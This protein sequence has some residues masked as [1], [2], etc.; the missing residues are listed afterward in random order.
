MTNILVE[1]AKQHVWQEPLQ[2][3]QFNI[4]LGRLTK[5]GGFVGSTAV[6]WHRVLSPTRRDTTRKFHHIYQ[7]GQV[8]PITLNLVNAF[9]QDVWMPVETIVN[10]LDVLIE[11]Y[12]ETGAIVPLNHVWIMRDFTNNL[13]L[14]VY[15]D[16]SVDYGSVL[17]VDEASDEIGT[18]RINCDNDRLVTRFY[19]NALQDNAEFNAVSAVQSDSVKTTSK[20][21]NGPDSYNE[22]ISATTSIRQQFSS[23]GM[24]LWYE[25]GFLVNAPAGHS[26]EMDGKLCRL[27]WDETFKFR[28][29]FALN[30]LP[31]FTSSLDANRT[32]YL[33]LCDTM[34]DVIDFYDD[35]DFYLV[36]G[37]S[38]RFKGV[39]INRAHAENIRQ[40]THNAYAIDAELI[41]WYIRQHAFLSS[42]TDV[43]ILIQVR[44]GGMSRRVFTQANRIDELFRLPYSNILNAF[45][46]TDAVV[47]EWSARELENSPYV[48]LMGAESLDLTP[49]LV[50]AAYGYP[51]ISQ[52]V[53]NPVQTV[54]AGIVTVPT[55]LQLLD[56][57]T[58]QGVRSVFCYDAEGIY[59]GYFN[60]TSIHPDINVSDRYIT[61]TTTECFRMSA[62]S[63]SQFSGITYN[64]D[65]VNYSLQEYGFRAYACSLVDGVPSEVWEDITDKP[66]YTYTPSKKGN[67]SKLVWNRALLESTGLVGCVK[68]NKHILINEFEFN[69]PT[70]RGYLSFVLRT[71]H[72]WDGVF[73]VRNQT[74][75]AAVVEVFANGEQLVEGI[76]YYL[77]FPTLVINNTT[78]CNSDQT[79]IIV[80][81]YGCGNPKT[82]KPYPPVEVGFVTAGYLSVDGRYDISRHRTNKVVV[83]S[84]FVNKEDVRFSEYAL[85]GALYPV[86][87]RPYMIQDYIPNVE[88]FA[89]QTT[90]TLYQEMCDTDRRLGDYLTQFLPEPVIVRPT[91]QTERWSL[92]SPVVSTLLQRMSEGYMAD[93]VV[94]VTMSL[95]D[96][97]NWF[98]PFRWLL[99]YDPAFK[100]L[101]E[102]FVH[103][104]PHP[105]DNTMTCSARQYRFIEQICSFYLNNRVDLTP[106]VEIG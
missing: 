29:L 80:R 15:H 59:L 51:G 74:I 87:G 27:V 60:N 68:V 49:E 39:Y 25:D 34:Y 94:P 45:K 16:R 96:I 67:P 69:K 44:E 88:A 103:I 76:D 6:L 89:T 4:G 83:N 85:T 5:N 104:R 40:V 81:S 32:K 46:D 54:Q 28:Q 30:D 98:E 23:K 101:D 64:Q 63:D 70:Y 105:H 75:P 91:V 77:N 53:V 93:E 86:D 35:V 47:N 17:R 31:V 92:V 82:L 99:D 24:G 12:F 22:F 106:Y 38:S 8:S 14:C 65:V 79:T 73:E 48:A 18:V 2:D 3:R 52:T 61:A 37:N 58:N 19:S 1:H 102:R 41:R 100:D 7:I 84:R 26:T 13:I 43:H 97:N 57:G 36:S 78:V 66:Y 95:E 20:R 71:L 50:T 56:P 72:N 9:E 33:L 42:A 55:G 90:T 62:V 11:V 21:I 10:E